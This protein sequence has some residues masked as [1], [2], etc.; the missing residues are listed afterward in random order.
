MN[1][2]VFTNKRI[3]QEVRVIKNENN[4]PLFCLSDVCR[5]L[6]I[7]TP[8]RVKESINREFEDGVSLT[9]S[10]QTLQIVDSLGRKQEATF[11]TEPQLYFVLMRSDKPQAKIFRQWVISKVLPAIR[12]TGKFTFTKSKT[13]LIQEEQI[14]QLNQNVK[15]TQK[16]LKEITKLKKQLSAKQQILSE[17]TSS[18]YILQQSIT[19][20][21]IPDLVKN[22][23]PQDLSIS[24]NPYQYIPFNLSN[25]LLTDNYIAS[26]VEFRKDYFIQDFNEKEIIKISRKTTIAKSN[27]LILITK[28]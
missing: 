28:S 12:K 19:I 24:K 6:D 17:L 16:V 11:I 3:G 1:P 8:A 14:N 23:Q 26:K 4:E 13:S 9:H 5:A 7:T 20:P 21:D 25:G 15:K 27:L 22:N 2:I 18:I 10:I